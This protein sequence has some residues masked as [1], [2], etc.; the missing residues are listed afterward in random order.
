MALPRRQPQSNRRSIPA[1]AVLAWFLAT[2]LLALAPL[3]YF[4]SGSSDA[5]TEAGRLGLAVLPMLMAWPLLTFALARV[6]RARSAKTRLGPAAVRAS[7]LMLV[8][9]GLLLLA[10]HVGNV[11]AIEGDRSW[12]FFWCALAI[13]WV[14]SSV[15]LARAAKGASSGPPEVL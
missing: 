8:A 15:A 1:I 11:V 3:L 5:A 13:A 9:A 14:V 10:R 2:C 7:L 6:G 12:V 4:V